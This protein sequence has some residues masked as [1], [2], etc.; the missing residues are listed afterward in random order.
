MNKKEEI[1]KIR[2]EILN[3][4][5]S[6]LYKYRT[7]NN[8]FSVIGKGSLDA[9]IVFVGEAPGEK[10]ALSGIPFCGRSGKLLDEMLLS[11][12]LSREKIYITN[13]V[14]DRPQDNRDPTKEEIKLYSQFLDRQLEIIK[15]KV[16][17]M[18]G[19]LSMNYLFEKAGIKQK[20]ESI[21][22]MHGKIFKTRL[23]YGEVILLPLYHPAYALYNP[24][25]KKVLFD[26]FKKVKKFIGDVGREK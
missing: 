24:N 5:K 21:G 7:D 2:K 14:N 18:L 16:I 6:P 26:D 8:Y 4:K 11:V 3:L 22:E 25:N 10:E 9:K 17:I 23:S 15:P 12:K 13:L 19:R 1:E 20:L